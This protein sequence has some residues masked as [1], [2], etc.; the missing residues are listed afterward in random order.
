MITF[1]AICCMD[2]AENTLLLSSIETIP[3][4]LDNAKAE[5]APSSEKSKINPAPTAL[6]GCSTL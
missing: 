4:D 2:R 6:L 3:Q 1:C 5:E